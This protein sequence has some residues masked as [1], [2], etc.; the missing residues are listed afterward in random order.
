[1][2][3]NQNQ[4]TPS[5]QEQ[6][7][8]ALLKVIH[9]FKYYRYRAMN[10]IDKRKRDYAQLSSLHK[11]LIPQQC[12]RLDLA[13]DRIVR[14]SKFIK[15]MIAEIENMP[16]PESLKDQ[17]NV[18]E[19]DFDKVKTTLKQ[20]TRDWSEQGLQERNATYTPLLEAIDTHFK[21]VPV[22]KRNQIKILVPGAGLGRL[23]FDIAS[24]GY[25][26]QGNE[27]SFYMLIASHFILNRSDRIHQYTLYPWVHSFSNHSVKYGVG[28]DIRVPDVDIS[29]SIPP[30]TE[31]SMV[32]GDFTMAYKDQ[33]CSWDAVVTCF[34][35][36]T[37]HN[38]IEYLEIIYNILK[39]GGVW[40]N[41]GPLLYHFEGSKENSIELS[42]DQILDISK[43][44][45]FD[46]L[47]TESKKCTYCGR[48]NDMLEYV[49]NASFWVAIKR[50]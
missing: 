50:E 3:E 46:I 13:V 14:N 25:S 29:S 24:K 1:M 10:H 42:L 32:G 7:D 11:S 41:L 9:A 12:Q 30:G 8:L 37:A 22:E 38:I 2:F 31:F 45:G 16:I 5:E 44:M 4:F 18:T 15:L 19:M 43:K 34:F 17:V 49:Y 48:P 39:P 21:D 33:E 28:N 6:E 27:F 26:C 40:I 23:A 47:F 35:I 36:D 20:F